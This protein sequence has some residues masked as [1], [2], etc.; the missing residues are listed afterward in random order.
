MGASFWQDFRSKLGV[1]LTYES[2]RCITGVQIDDSAK[3]VVQCDVDVQATNDTILYQQMLP[4][5][6]F[7][8]QSPS[9]EEI[10]V[11]F[12]PGLLGLLPLQLMQWFREA[13]VFVHHR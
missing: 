6:V 12:L 7:N 3:I 8:L 1:G 2:P 9:L 13:P 11:V 5:L 10:V 4:L